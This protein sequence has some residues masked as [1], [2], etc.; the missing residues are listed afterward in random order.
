MLHFHKRQIRKEDGR[1][2]LLYGRQTHT[3]P[4]QT[5]LQLLMERSHSHLR[6][7]P[8][9]Q[10]WVCYAAHRQDR[11]FKPPT[12]YCPFC[13]TQRDGFPTEIPFSDFEVAVFDNRFPAFRLQVQQ[14]SELPIPSQ[15]AIGH[16]EIVVYSAEHHQSFGSLP[17]ERLELIVRVWADR[18]QELLAQESIQFV[19]PFENRGEEVGVTLHHPHGQIYAF[20]YLPPVIEKMRSAFREQPILQAL[21]RNI[22]DRY[23]IFS[24][25]EVVAFVPPFQRHPYEVWLTTHRFHP[26]LWTFSDSEVRSL[27]SALGR[28]VRLYDRVFDRPFP[29]IMLLY[30]APKGEEAY[31]QFH[32]Q[33]LPFLRSADKL[34]YI[35]GCEIGAG[36][37]LVDMVPE[38]TVKILR[39]YCR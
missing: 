14:P 38:E 31:F 11:T 7:H 12:E 32:I 33:F 28:I 19:M 35:A 5:N 24:D 10:E 2:L 17:Q 3:L 37:F 21:R 1:Q 39:Y 8:L 30:A 6:W 36:T 27:A 16:C 18:Y 25:E 9:R 20:S 34:K 23:D 15:S 22:S 4:W 13:P 26:G 29:Y